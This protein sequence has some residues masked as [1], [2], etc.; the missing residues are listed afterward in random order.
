M[1]SQSSKSEGV[2]VMVTED[3]IKRG[4]AGDIKDCPIKLALTDAGFIDVRVDQRA[5][6]RR[7]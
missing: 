6:L 7:V 5:A 1:E 3:H 4:R 2:R